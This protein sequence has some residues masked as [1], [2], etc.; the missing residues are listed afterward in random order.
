[1][2][3]SRHV[4]KEKQREE[5][6]VQNFP[7]KENLFTYTAKYC[8]NF[9]ILSDHNKFLW[10]MTTEDININQKLAN[11]VHSCFEIRKK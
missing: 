10:L 11:Y 6:D 1:M 4:Y 3:Y 9:D 2:F 7:Y 5:R 8:S